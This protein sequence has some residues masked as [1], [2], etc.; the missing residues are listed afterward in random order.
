MKR[1]LALMMVLIMVIGLLCGCNRTIL[2]TTY[3]FERAM[4]ALPDGEVVEGKC[5][6]WKDWEDGTVQVVIDGKTYYTHS[7]NVILISE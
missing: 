5:S 2:D 4:V 1:L 3:S 7:T 6:G